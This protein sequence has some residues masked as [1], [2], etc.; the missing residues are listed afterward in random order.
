MIN[1][2]HGNSGRVERV[3]DGQGAF[4]APDIAASGSNASG[5]RP[6]VSVSNAGALNAPLPSAAK[7]TPGAL[8]SLTGLT[9][10]FPDALRELRSLETED[11]L[12]L[13]VL[14]LMYRESGDTELL[15]V[16]GAMFLP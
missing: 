7:T 16:M 6:A 11:I 9:R 2:Y 14:Y 1:R 12:L 3:D 15:I 4:H 13:A 8:G 5:V 10:L